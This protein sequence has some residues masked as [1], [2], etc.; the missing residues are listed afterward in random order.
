MP[1]LR[2]KTVAASSSAISLARKSFGDLLA[3]RSHV[4]LQR[5]IERD[6]AR[7]RPVLE[8]FCRVWAQALR[9]IQKGQ[10][11]DA[12]FGQI[13]ELCER[14]GKRTFHCHFSGILGSELTHALA[15]VAQELAEY[16]ED[17]KLPLFDVFGKH[18]SE[19]KQ[20]KLQAACG[21]KKRHL[22]A[23]QKRR[24]WHAVFGVHRAYGLLE[25]GDF[26]EIFEDKITKP[27]DSSLHALVLGANN[28][29]PS[30][31]YIILGIAKILMTITVQLA[32]NA[33]FALCQRYGKDAKDLPAG[34]SILVHPR[35]LEDGNLELS[36]TDNGTGIRPEH[37]PRVFEP[38]F[39]TKGRKGG[40]M[41]LSACKELI[42]MLGGT[43]QVESEWGKGTTV[44]LVI[45]KEFVETEGHTPDP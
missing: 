45:P 31:K 39:S 9:R 6:K 43:I 26:I 37:L 10:D 41:G 12:Q 20:R 14:F 3:E 11:P 27:S 29:I 17:K 2:R 5:M 32:E 13:E 36:F 1:T 35:I 38:G 21:S 19:A 28:S 18:L 15:H 22:T 34:G 23:Q 33:I 4:P 24:I 7:M 30:G 44:T 25:P 42:E 40:G 16:A 8:E